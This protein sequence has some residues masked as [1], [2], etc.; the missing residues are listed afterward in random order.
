[1]VTFLNLSRFNL[2]TRSNPPLSTERALLGLIPAPSLTLSS[3]LD[4]NADKFLKWK[5]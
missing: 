4:V 1:M 3:L 2:F 5:C